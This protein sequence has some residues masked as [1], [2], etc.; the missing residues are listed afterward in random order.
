MTTTLTD[1]TLDNV[2]F[3]KFSLADSLAAFEKNPKK[4][5]KLVPLKLKGNTF[6]LTLHGELFTEGILVSDE[7]NTHSIGFSFEDEGDVTSFQ[8]LYN[9]FDSIDGEL[10]GWEARE[11]V[12]NDNQLWLK[13]KY[14]KDKNSY[15]FKSN[16]KLLPKKPLDAPLQIGDT[17]SATVDVSAYFGLE[18]HVYG[19]C[20]TLRELKVGDIEEPAAKKQK[21]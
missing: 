6:K 11:L 8:L 10:E 20:L 18:D 7:Y 5:I 19:L 21:V 14:A 12:K 1:I 3:S 13:F 4:A 9:V 15:K 17:V 16:V 2:Q